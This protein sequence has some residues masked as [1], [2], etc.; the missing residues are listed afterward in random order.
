M[1]VDTFKSTS[2]L[3][4]FKFRD[5]CLGWV[6]ISLNLEHKI[7]LFVLEPVV[8]E[9]EWAAPNNIEQSDCLIL[10]YCLIRHAWI[11]II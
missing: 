7:G 5:N 1:R 11:N 6:E 8:S 3:F 9:Y 4:H 10:V 2:S